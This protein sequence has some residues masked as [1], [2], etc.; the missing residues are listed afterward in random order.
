MQVNG[1]EMTEQPPPERGLWTWEGRLPGF[2]GANAVPP[3][4][5]IQRL[6]RAGKSRREQ[7]PQGRNGTTAGLE[8]GDVRRGEDDHEIDQHV[9]KLLHRDTSMSDEVVEEMKEMWD[10]WV[11]RIIRLYDRNGREIRWS[12][13][14]RL[15]WGASGYKVVRKNFIRGREI[16][17]CWIPFAEEGQEDGPTFETYLSFGGVARVLQRARTEM[18][19]VR[20]HYMTLGELLFNLDDAS[21]SEVRGWLEI[22]A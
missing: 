10:E 3:V 21:L 20:L 13:M 16:V 17:T 12:E 8:L 5:R 1:L 22:S 18:E 4:K 11:T 7:S 2:A 15:K 6:D 14:A 19:A 9:F